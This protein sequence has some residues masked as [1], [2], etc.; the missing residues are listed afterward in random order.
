MAF[1]RG[2]ELNI[3]VEGSCEGILNGGSWR[4]RFS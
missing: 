2:G 1:L 4:V 3:N